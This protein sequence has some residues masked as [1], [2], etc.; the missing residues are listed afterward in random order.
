MINTAVSL[1]KVEVVFVVKTP[2]HVRTGNFDIERVLPHWSQ[3]LMSDQ[4]RH[5]NVSS[6]GPT[7]RKNIQDRR[8]P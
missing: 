6:E 5:V 1:L 8:E 4:I 2:I 7:R 3:R